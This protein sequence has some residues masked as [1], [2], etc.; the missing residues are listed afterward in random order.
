MRRRG[1]ELIFSRFAACAWVAVIFFN[2]C[3]R[4]STVSRC[5]AEPFGFLR[6]EKRF[7][8]RIKPASRADSERSSLEAFFPK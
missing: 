4:S 2:S 6:G 8:L 5:T 7:G 1:C 3:N